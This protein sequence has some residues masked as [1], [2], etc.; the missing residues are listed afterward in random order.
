MP[1]E[2]DRG[3][4]FAGVRAIFTY[5]VSFLILSLPDSIG[6]SRV[7]NPEKESGFSGQAGE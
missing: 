7:G 2:C 5:F 4:P 3:F 1:L 6:E